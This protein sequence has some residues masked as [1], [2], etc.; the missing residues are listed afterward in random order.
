L[1]TGDPNY[2][3]SSNAGKADVY[4]INYR[5]TARWLLWQGSEQ[6]QGL[7]PGTRAPASLSFGYPPHP[8]GDTNLLRRID[9]AHQSD[10]D[11]VPIFDDRVTRVPECIIGRLQGAMPY[12]GDISSTASRFSTLKPSTIRPATS[13][14]LA[15]P[16]FQT[17]TTAGL[18]RSTW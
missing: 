1:A 14:R 2:T 9:R 7:K 8:L 6:N 11:S 17:C 3:S 4:R 5:N 15:H 12:A 10:R 16:L 18:S 13:A